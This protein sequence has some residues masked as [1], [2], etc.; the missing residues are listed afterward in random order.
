MIQQGASEGMRCRSGCPSSICSVKRVFIP[1]MLCKWIEALLPPPAEQI[2]HPSTFPTLQYSSLIDLHQPAFPHSQRTFVGSDILSCSVAL[3]LSY[4]HVILQVYP[5]LA[6]H[7]THT[8]LFHGSLRW[9]VP[10]L[11]PTHCAWDHSVCSNL[12]PEMFA[13][14]KCVFINVVYWNA[15]APG[16]SIWARLC[17][18]VCSTETIDPYCSQ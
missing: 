2:L 17:T 16:V 3:L 14:Y 8:V 11:L 1:H 13:G 9:F 5:R 6:V 10:H 12:L 7:A 18:R 4:D 15:R